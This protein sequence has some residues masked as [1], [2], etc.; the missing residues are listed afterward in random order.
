MGT[1]SL[2]ELCIGALAVEGVLCVIAL[3]V[4][5]LTRG[6][7]REPLGL[8]RGTLSAWKCALLAVGT[9]ALSAG[10][11]GA[12][13]LTGLREG[14]PLEE[15]AELLAGSRGSDFA[16]ALLALGLAPGVAEELLCR[17]LVQR[18]LSARLGNAGAVVLAALVFGALH[19][20][21]VHGGFAVVLG[22]YLGV[23]AARANSIRPAIFCH[24][25]NNLLAVYFGAWWP[26]QSPP[27]PLG[28][29]V[30][31]ALALGCLWFA[32]RPWPW[33]DT[34]DLQV[35]TGSDDG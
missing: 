23:A 20:D 15:F 1:P 22:L 2:R 17:G 27:G 28:M 29:G 34:S 35:A 32:C 21:L 24:T 12:I 3:A 11:D 33:P 10:L 6:G 30:A 25:A 16:L 14:T 9:V 4:A 26:E 8:A 31:V 19:A 7:L 18:G 5:W 13:E